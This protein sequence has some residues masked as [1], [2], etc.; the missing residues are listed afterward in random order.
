MMADREAT[1]S[2]L[3]AKASSAVP[4][5]EDEQVALREKLETRFKQPLELRFAV[6]PSLLGG[7]VVHIGDQI[8]DGS[9]KG[10]LDALTQTLGSKQ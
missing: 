2:G 4:L 6:D 3:A 10:R 1:S 5:S 8:I 7:V 9:V